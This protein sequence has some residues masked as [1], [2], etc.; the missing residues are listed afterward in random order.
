MK[1]MR[2]LENYLAKEKHKKRNYWITYTLIFFI[3]LCFVFSSFYIKKSVQ[4]YKK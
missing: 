3:M 4:K 1:I 2:Y